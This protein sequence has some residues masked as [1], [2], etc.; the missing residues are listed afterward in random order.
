MRQHDWLCSPE[1][2]A[3]VCT[4]N[5]NSICTAY[6]SCWD[7]DSAFSNSNRNLPM[8]LQRTHVVSFSAKG[9]S[10]KE[11]YDVWFLKIIIPFLSPKL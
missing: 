4:D 8:P 7:F 11:F 3:E 5:F 2:V 1:E 6:S 10:S 9:V